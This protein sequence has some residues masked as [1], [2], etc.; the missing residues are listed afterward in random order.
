MTDPLTPDA[1]ADESGLLCPAC[2]GSDLAR[3]RLDSVTADTVTRR[4][5]CENCGATWLAVY[6]LTWY[7]ELHVP[8]DHEGA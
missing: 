3:G 4:W 2:K 5:A 6:T 7:D 1:Y 8:E